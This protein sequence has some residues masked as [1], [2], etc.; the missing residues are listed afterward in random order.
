MTVVW[1]QPHCMHAQCAI[2]MEK[3]DEETRKEHTHRDV[4]L[5]GLEATRAAV[6][7]GPFLGAPRRCVASQ[8]LDILFKLIAAQR[9]HTAHIDAAVADAARV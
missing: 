4:V 3:K 8:A 1:L 9:G 6:E 7:R 2:Y 5:A